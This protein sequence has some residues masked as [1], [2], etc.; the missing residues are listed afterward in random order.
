MKRL[1]DPQ[2]PD[3]VFLVLFE[4]KREI[5]A[6]DETLHEVYNWRREDDGWR[7]FVRVVTVGEKQMVESDWW[8]LPIT[9][10]PRPTQELPED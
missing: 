10:Y 7:V 5:I 1:Q 9:L 3:G 2:S 6:I 8:P 4:T